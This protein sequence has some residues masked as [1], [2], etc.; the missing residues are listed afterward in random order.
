MSYAFFNVFCRQKNVLD[1]FLS[2][3]MSSVYLS[4][5]LILCISCELR[6]TV[7]PTAKNTFYLLFVDLSYN[8]AAKKRTVLDLEDKKKL[9][10]AF[11]LGRS[12]TRS[13]RCLS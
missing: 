12:Q 8:M 9:I 10:D 7:M 6:S 3:V 2:T 5:S 13:S 1:V 11:E 4:A